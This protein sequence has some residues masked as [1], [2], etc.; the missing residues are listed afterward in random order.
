M[1]VH[2]STERQVSEDDYNLFPVY[3]AYY[4]LSL[5]VASRI[6]TFAFSRL[7]RASWSTASPSK[8]SNVVTYVLEIVVTS[9][10][11][12]ITFTLGHSLLFDK[13]PTT[14]AQQLTDIE[15][16]YV[17]IT[18]LYLFE[19]I[20]RHNTNLPL[21][22][23]HF[24]TVIFSCLVVEILKHDIR[25]SIPYTFTPTG[26]HVE[27]P[28]LVPSDALMSG[29]RLALLMTLHA[30]TEQPTFIGEYSI[31]IASLLLHVNNEVPIL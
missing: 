18:A 21:V 23:H 31:N 8:R 30:T 15:L 20:Y 22:I 29:M 2:L 14:T 12:I 19:L 1:Y 27:E 24:V 13:Y 25:V 26:V 16:V 28:Q 11:L 4:M 9:I 3:F 7:K 17:I 10:L 5:Y 6:I